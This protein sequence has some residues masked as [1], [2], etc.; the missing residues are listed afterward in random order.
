M[1]GNNWTTRNADWAKLSKPQQ[2][3]VRDLRKAKKERQKHKI[4]ATQQETDT[5][6]DDSDASTKDNAGTKFGR[7]AHSKKMKTDKDKK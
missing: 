1:H 3:K 7:N 4:K 6:D 2:D 5:S